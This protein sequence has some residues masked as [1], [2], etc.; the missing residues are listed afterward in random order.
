MLDNNTFAYI[1]P[2]HHWKAI[3]ANVVGNISQMVVLIAMGLPGALWFMRHYWHLEPLFVQAFAVMTVLTL[4]FLFV[5]YFNIGLLVP[6]ARRIPM[7]HRIKHFVKDVRVLE[8]FNRREL[9]DVLRWAAIRYLIYATQYFCLLYFFGIKTGLMGGFS[10]IAAIFLLQTSIP[11]PPI[12][13]LLARGGLAIQVWSVFEAN[14]I[15]ALAATFSLWI[16]NLILPAL[17][18]TFSL[19]YVNI[20]KNLGYDD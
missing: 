8:Q 10:G 1:R 19:F 9:A 18:G 17:V 3:I 13:G 15:S 4:A 14:E 20:S 16:I 6:L 2:E 5:V 11:L 7:L 12:T